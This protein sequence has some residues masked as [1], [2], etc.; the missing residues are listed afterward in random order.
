V[1]EVEG[2]NEGVIWYIS[3]ARGAGLGLGARRD[4]QQHGHND[5]E[6]ERP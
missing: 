3:S 1:V 4:E 2:V 5:K 6:Q